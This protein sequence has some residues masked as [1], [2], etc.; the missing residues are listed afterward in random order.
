[1]RGISPGANPI[2]A[3][4]NLRGRAKGKIDFRELARR[5]RLH[6]SADTSVSYMG[7]AVKA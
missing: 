1:M 6:E 7:Y 2:S 5:M 4:L 3:L